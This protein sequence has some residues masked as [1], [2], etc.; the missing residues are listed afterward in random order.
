[1]VWLK[2]TCLAHHKNSRGCSGLPVWKPLVSVT[3]P[4]L[5]ADTVNLHERTCCAIM[6]GYVNLRL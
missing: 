6:S 5:F 3:Q 2:T 4:I 1:M